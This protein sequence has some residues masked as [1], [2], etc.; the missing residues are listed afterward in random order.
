MPI[1]QRPSSRFVMV[2]AFRAKYG[3]AVVLLFVGGRRKHSVKR[4][5]KENVNKN[6]EE[7][8]SVMDDKIIMPPL[9]FFVCLLTST[10]NLGSTIGFAVGSHLPVLR[11]CAKPQAGV[12]PPRPS[13]PC[14][15]TYIYIPLS[16]LESRPDIS[17]TAPLFRRSG[18]FVSLD[19]LAY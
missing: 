7:A 2:Y 11:A 16:S 15:Y 12:S 14:I 3:S 10:V 1:R 13:F 6:V 4:N 17:P 5:H 8:T 9:H 19:R 18:K